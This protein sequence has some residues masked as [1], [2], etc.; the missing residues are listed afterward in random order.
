MTDA[1]ARRLAAL[2]KR[3]RSSLSP[4]ERDAALGA[5][6]DHAE[7]ILHELV[8]SVLL[9]ET[10]TAHARAAH[11]RLRESFV[12]YN[13]LR[14][15]APEDI[16]QAIGERYPLGVERAI[17][18]RAILSDV[19]SRRHALSLTHLNELPK[20]D[21]RTFLESLD[22]CPHFAAARV[23]LLRLG[24]HAVPVDVR[25]RDLLAAERIVEADATP[26][27]ASGR[28]ERTIR[29][30]DSQEVCMILQAWSDQPPPPKEKPRKAPGARP[31][32]KAA[33]RRSAS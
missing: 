26:E 28:L 5:P 8:F 16:V 14:V 21:A 27:A 6:E 10:T 31:R 19:F 32:K 3:L 4:G 1:S 20:R 11:K 24:G 13:E 29:A 30:D 18:L 22:G 15:S 23:F 2:L 9:W 12:D 7:A 33:T 17:R 25:L